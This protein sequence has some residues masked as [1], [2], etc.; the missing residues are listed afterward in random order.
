MA[1]QKNGCLSSYQIVGRNYS[2]PVYFSN[3]E[4]L[5]SMKELKQKDARIDP[6]K[7]L[8]ENSPLNGSLADCNESEV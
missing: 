4:F 6:L 1:F 3:I 2:D 8:S 5:E 7:T